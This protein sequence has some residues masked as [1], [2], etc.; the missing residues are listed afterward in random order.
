MIE[1]LK[2][3]VDSKDLTREWIEEHFKQTGIMKERVKSGSYL[4]TGKKR[5]CFIFEEPSNLTLLSFEQ[6][7]AFLGWDFPSIREVPRESMWETSLQNEVERLNALRYHLIILRSREVGRAAQA[8]TYSE[9]PVI[10]A[11]ESFTANDL[12]NPSQHPT[13]AL[14]DIYTIYQ[15]FGRIDGL[16]I[17][18]AGDLRSNQVVN[19]M[20]FNLSQF[21]PQS[22]V[23]ASRAG[24]FKLHPDVEA[25]L[26]ASDT[27]VSKTR[28][29][30]DQLSAADVV[31]L[32]KPKYQSGHPLPDVYG[33]TIEEKELDFLPPDSVVLHDMFRG[34]IP[35][36][37]D[38]P[39]VRWKSQ[40]DNGICVR[41]AL[42][43]MLLSS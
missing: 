30:H 37:R 2:H 29:L 21:Q 1:R 15:H 18:F 14:A 27:P 16:R 11:G 5:V 19:S 40:V 35:P 22:I 32:T 41:M 6:A 26:A 13:Q 33:D 31:Y 24:S 39:R 9:V 4:T 10:N 34:E 42:M 12:V 28:D 3:L 25:H 8:A 7:I 17:V 23:L 38:N 43:K 36:F 20:L